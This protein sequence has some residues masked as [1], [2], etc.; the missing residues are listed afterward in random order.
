[1][2]G[3]GTIECEA[4]EVILHVIADKHSEHSPKALLAI[5]MSK[6]R[7]F[8]LVLILVVLL[9]SVKVIISLSIQGCDHYSN[10]KEKLVL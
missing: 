8:L 4:Q 6:Y 1:M 2:V 7:D 9:V 10:Y 5:V 3:N